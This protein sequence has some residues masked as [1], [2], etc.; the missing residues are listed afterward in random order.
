MHPNV[1]HR[2]CNATNCVFDEDTRIQTQSLRPLR[3]WLVDPPFP[4][5]TSHLT[6]KTGEEI[7]TKVVMF[8]NVA[9]LITLRH[10]STLWATQHGGQDVPEVRDTWVAGP[11]SSRSISRNALAILDRYVGVV[12]STPPVDLYHFHEYR[13]DC[14]KVGDRDTAPGYRKTLGRA[15]STNDE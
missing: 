9:K 4:I 7:H 8:D 12:F 2:D 6:L 3:R 5:R 1:R 13:Y 11:A 14:N 10:F 15:I